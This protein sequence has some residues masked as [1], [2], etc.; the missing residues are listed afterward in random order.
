[1]MQEFTKNYSGRT[2]ST[3]EFKQIVEKHMLPHMNLDGNG[4]MDWFFNQWVYGTEVP[5]YKMTYSL[6]PQGSNAALQLKVVQSNVSDSFKM[7]VRLYISVNERILPLAR[8][9]IQGSRE[10]DELKINLP[11]QTKEILLNYNYDVLSLESETMR[12]K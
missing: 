11:V 7:P 3:E 2:A 6:T 5:K 4:K 8:I 1:M 9:A 12:A 10:S